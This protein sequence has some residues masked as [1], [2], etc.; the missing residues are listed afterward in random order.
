MIEHHITTKERFR[1]EREVNKMKV[2][3]F[4]KEQY[5]KFDNLDY[6]KEDLREGFSIDS[7][8]YSSVIEA[9]DELSERENLDFSEENFHKLV[10]HFE[11]SFSPEEKEELCMNKY[12]G[13][14]TN[15]E[16]AMESLLEFYHSIYERF[17]S[18]L[19]SNSTARR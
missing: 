8:W 16:K 11:D 2:P 17:T 10:H 12:G 13:V 19:S 5:R 3:H 18:K 15:Q 6:L 14:M 7:C 9:G 1:S 4:I